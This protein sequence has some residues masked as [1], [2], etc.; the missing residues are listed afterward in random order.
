LG[1]N[2]RTKITTKKQKNAITS[3]YL[4]N[5]CRNERRGI[6]VSEY[7]YYINI[8]NNINNKIDMIVIV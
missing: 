4:G 8:N 6:F 3:P 2:D 5:F 1:L 7:L